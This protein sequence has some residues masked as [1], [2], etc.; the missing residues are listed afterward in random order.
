MLA[1]DPNKQAIEKAKLEMY[2]NAMEEE[3][4]CEEKKK[5][6]KEEKHEME[7]DNSG[8]RSA[9]MVVKPPAK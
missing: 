9:H 5:E 3:G 6:Q 2:S 8:T 7:E 4:C 1:A